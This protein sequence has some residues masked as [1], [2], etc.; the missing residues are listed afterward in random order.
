MSSGAEIMQLARIVGKDELLNC[1]PLVERQDLDS[2]DQ[3]Q[4]ACV[5]DLVSSSINRIT[6]TLVHEAMARDDIQDAA[7][8]SAYLEERLAFFGELF[9][10]E[11][12][13]QIRQGFTAI[14][15]SWG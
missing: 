3:S 2:L 6:K 5:H 15:Q 10:E 8:A 14:T 12:R 4:L 13:R 11:Q 1:V 9:T 7:G